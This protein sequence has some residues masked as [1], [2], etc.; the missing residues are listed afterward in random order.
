MFGERAR[1]T[2]ADFVDSVAS[3]TIPQSLL[4]IDETHGYALKSEI[5]VAVLACCSEARL[6]TT[7]YFDVFRQQHSVA[8]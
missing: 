8:K 4:D 1:S 6:H 2:G 7:V 5:R 3:N